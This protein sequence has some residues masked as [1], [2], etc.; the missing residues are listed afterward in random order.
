MLSES[1]ERFTALSVIIL[2]SSL[3]QEVVR[4]LLNM[5]LDLDLKEKLHV[6]DL[7]YDKMVKSGHNHDFIR[8]IFVEG[9]LKFESMVKNSFLE[10]SSPKFRPLYMAND[11]DRENRARDKFLKK[12]NWYDTEIE[13]DKNSWKADIPQALKIVP[14]GS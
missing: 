8:V 9:L 11:Y 10:E 6:L 5:H 13:V 4:R 2:R 7:F 14:F 1:S 12:F 3:R